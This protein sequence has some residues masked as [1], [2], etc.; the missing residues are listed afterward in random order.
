M[1]LR[2]N[3]NNNMFHQLS[4]THHAYKSHTNLYNQSS[5]IF[6]VESMPNHP[7]QSMNIELCFIPI[8]CHFNYQPSHLFY[9]PRS[10]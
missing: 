4:N 10:H 3:Q 6:H 1:E 7:S 2:P 9:I 8:P 5:F